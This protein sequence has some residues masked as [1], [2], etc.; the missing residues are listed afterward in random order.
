MKAYQLTR[1]FPGF[2]DTNE[3]RDYGV[4]KKL[5]KA[6]K[7]AQKVWDKW[8]DNNHFKRER[9]EWDESD[10]RQ[11]YGTVDSGNK[12]HPRMVVF[13]IHPTWKIE[14]PKL[15]YSFDNWKREMFE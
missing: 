2:V 12:E 6:K 4:H 3:R 11:F 10:E 9:I 14:L 8:A 5:R 13:L 7:E 15:A 1:Y